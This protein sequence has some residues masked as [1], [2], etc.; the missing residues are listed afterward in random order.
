MLQ[1]GSSK[2]YLD[3]RATVW[4]VC[5]ACH[6]MCGSCK[7]LCRAQMSLSA[8]AGVRGHLCHQLLAL[9]AYW[10]CLLTEVNV[11]ANQ[12]F[13]E[14]LITLMLFMGHIS[15]HKKWAQGGHGN[16]GQSPLGPSP[17]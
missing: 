17:L 3:V 8:P 9:L 10:S 7:G 1:S 12:E 16:H 6:Y 5:T 15:C 14:P 2:V 13:K 4:L 11:P